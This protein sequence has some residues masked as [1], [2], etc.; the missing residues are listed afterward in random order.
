MSAN[1]IRKIEGLENLT[2]L[3]VLDVG[4]N[5]IRHIE[6][7][8]HLSKLTEFYAAKNKLM[9]LRFILIL[10]VISDFAENHHTRLRL[11]DAV[12]PACARYGRTGSSGARPRTSDQFQ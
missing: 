1:R 3:V 8:G 9:V 5:K 6:N 11:T 7:V 4:D 12:R 2:E 10:P